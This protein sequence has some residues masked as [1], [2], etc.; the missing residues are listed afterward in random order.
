MAGDAVVPG[1]SGGERKTKGILDGKRGSG[2]ATSQEPESLA[3]R[4]FLDEVPWA[5]W[6]QLQKVRFWPRRQL[7]GDET[8]WASVSFVRDALYVR[9]TVLRRVMLPCL[10]SGVV[11]TGV[12]TAQSARGAKFRLP[13]AFFLP[14]FLGTLAVLLFRLFGAWHSYRKGH[15]MVL[16]MGS[17]AMDALLTCATSIHVRSSGMDMTEMARRLNVLLALVRQDLR[18]SRQHKVEASAY[19]AG[20]KKSRL[21]KDFFWSTPDRFLDDPFGAPPLRLLLTA[22]EA[23]LYRDASPE[24]RVVMC[25]VSVRTLF[26]KHVNFGEE[27]MSTPEGKI[28]QQNV[29]AVVH[30]WRQC[31]EIVRTPAPFVLHHLGMLLALLVALV[32]APLF[33]AAGVDGYFPVATS[34]AATLLLYGIEEAA[35]EMEVPFGWRPTDTNLS[36][37]CRSFLKQSLTFLRICGLSRGAE[38]PARDDDEAEV[39]AHE[40]AEQ[41]EAGAE[42]AAEAPAAPPGFP[43][44]P[45]P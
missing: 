5:E 42:P 3:S 12:V 15:E 1:R 13:E 2:A 20:A 26:A 4:D 29:Q 6:A 23:D 9:G 39:E 16:L 7:G 32:W 33:F 25:V 8:A 41:Q 35:C 31:R 24:S 19:K 36:A 40:G 22:P 27:R 17:S 38:P 43:M 21:A 18:E 45:Q 10:L 28:F 44:P 14:I 34:M 30:S 11:T 37:M